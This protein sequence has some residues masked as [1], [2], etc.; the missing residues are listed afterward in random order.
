MSERYYQPV[1]EPAEV[2]EG[3][4]VFASRTMSTNSTVIVAGREAF[5]IDPAWQPDELTGIGDWLSSRDLAVTGAWCTHAHHDHVLW[6][7]SFGNASRW[8]TPTATRLAQRN[9]HG[10]LNALGDDWPTDLSSYVGDLQPFDQSEF[11][12]N[13]HRVNVLEHDGHSPGHSALWIGGLG[14]LVAGDMLS[15]IEIPLFEDSGITEYAAGLASLRETVL[16]A[17]ILIPGHGTIARAGT[18]DSPHRRWEV[19]H[20]YVDNLRQGIEPD[21]PRLANGAEWLRE[22]HNQNCSST[23]RA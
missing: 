10:L 3:V 1:A 4:Y 16:H 22:A 21:D 17:D 14:L 19:D 8:A 6:H 15:D 18:V 9:R 7:P 20:R 2:E 5:L 11:M 23:A 13:R 12:W